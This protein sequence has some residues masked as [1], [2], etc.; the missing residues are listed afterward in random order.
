MRASMIIYMRALRRRRRYFYKNAHTGFWVEWWCGVWGARRF[1]Y[2]QYRKDNQMENLCLMI[3]FVKGRQ[4]YVLVLLFT[5][6]K[7][8]FIYTKCDVGNVFFF[9][10]PYNLY[11]FFKQH[12]HIYRNIN[13]NVLIVQ[14]LVIVSLVVVYVCFAH[15][16]LSIF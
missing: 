16:Y 11:P 7:L 14:F 9:F 13:T 6:I 1:L 10:C 5:R 15:L 12:T 3:I 2:F 4:V 8:N